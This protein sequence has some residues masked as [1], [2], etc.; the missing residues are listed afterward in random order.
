LDIVTAKSLEPERPASRPGVLGSLILE[1][2]ITEILDVP[3]FL[4]SLEGKA[5]M[6]GN[7]TKEAGNGS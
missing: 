2:R 6:A 5:G 7:P 4:G 3:A 1:G